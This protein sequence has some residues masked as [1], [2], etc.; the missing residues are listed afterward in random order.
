MHHLNIFED[1]FSNNDSI[2]HKS[3]A[4]ISKMSKGVIVIIRQQNEPLINLITRQKSKSSKDELRNYG[5]GAQI[6]LD[7]GVRRMHLLTNSKRSVIGL[8]GYDLQICGYKNF[9]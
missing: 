6:L 1:V 5:I 8:D 2:L 4:K 3:I 7:L 9:D